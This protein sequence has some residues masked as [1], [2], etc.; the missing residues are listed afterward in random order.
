M[1]LALG[2]S[3]C[4]DST[5][6]QEE[7]ESEVKVSIALTPSLRCG[8]GTAGYVSPPKLSARQPSLYN[9]FLGSPSRCIGGQCL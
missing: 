9:P 4:R 2:F 5:G 8:L 1:Q 3:Q 6:G 7:E